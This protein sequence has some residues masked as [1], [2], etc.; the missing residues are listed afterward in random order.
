MGYASS[1][2]LLDSVKNSP[3]FKFVKVSIFQRTFLNFFQGNILSQD[4]VML[5][6]QE[7]QIDTVMHFAGET[8]VGL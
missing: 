6:L 1:D 7:F 8:H 4:L 5:V 3:N 2:I